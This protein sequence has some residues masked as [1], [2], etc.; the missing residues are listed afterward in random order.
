MHHACTSPCS[1]PGPPGR[2]ILTDLRSD[3]PLAAGQ[4]AGRAEGRCPPT[5]PPRSWRLYSGGEGEGPRCQRCVR[6]ACDLERE[7]GCS[8]GLS[9]ACPRVVCKCLSL[10][11]RVSLAGDRRIALF[12]SSGVRAG[13]QGGSPGWGGGQQVSRAVRAAHTNNLLDCELGQRLDD[14]S[15]I[16]PNFEVFDITCKHEGPTSEQA[17]DGKRLVNSGGP[18]TVRASPQ[19]VAD[20]RA[21]GMIRPSYEGDSAKSLLN[22]GLD[23]ARSGIHTA[24][25]RVSVSGV[26]ER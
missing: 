18:K 15:W 2:Q 16:V 11:R 9:R 23:V 21:V 1:R 5:P 26:R 6:G 24:A 14:S 10:V 3:L 20:V 4:R 12:R 19:G 7:A 13:G 22:L 25:R 17:H 8:A